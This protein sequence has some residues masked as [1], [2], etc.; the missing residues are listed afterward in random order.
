MQP[1]SIDIVRGCLENLEEMVFPEVSTPHGVSAVR[2]VRMMLKHL[3][4]RLEKEAA[5]L[6][7]DSKEKRELFS[8]A[9]AEAQLDERVRR[10][11]RQGVEAAPAPLPLVSPEALTAENDHWKRL[12]ERVLAEPGAEPIRGRIRRQLRAQ[13]DREAEYTVAAIDG[14]FF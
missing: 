14:P 9:A 10:I 6:V 12:A 11:I 13:M 7:L 2:G 5:A 1:S 3:V 8:Q 4:L